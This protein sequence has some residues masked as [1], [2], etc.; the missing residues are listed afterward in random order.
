MSKRVDKKKRHEMKRKHKMKYRKDHT[1]SN[2]MVM[3]RGHAFGKI[4]AFVI[5]GLVIGT[6]ILLNVF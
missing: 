2:V 6:I 5:I 4:V 1:P 3:Q